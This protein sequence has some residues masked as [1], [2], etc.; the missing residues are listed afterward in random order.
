MAAKIDIFSPEWC[1]IIFD[2]KNQSYGAFEI[3]KKS[4]KRHI[5][6][7]IIT[8][9]LFAVG[10]SMPG[11]I[12]RFAPKSKEVDVTVRTLSDLKLDKP[13]EEDNILK[14]LPPPPPPLRNTIKFTPPVIKPDE[15]VA[16]EE[17]P[18]LQEEVID[19]KSAIGTVTFDKGTDDVTAPLPTDDKAVSEEEDVPFV[20]VEQMPEFPG[21]ERALLKWVGKNLKYP[22]IAQENGVSGIVVVN[23]VVEPDGSISNVKVLSGISKDCDEEAKRVIS[24]MPKWKAGKQGGKSVRVFF[25]VPIRFVLE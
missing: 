19:A 9:F 25:T 6:G 17:E 13:K 21:G 7:L 10:F 2:E 11:L 18:K 4:S 14:D 5:Y 3:R 20:I 22:E 12:E 8:T 1:E 24:A 15:E 23:F 16:E